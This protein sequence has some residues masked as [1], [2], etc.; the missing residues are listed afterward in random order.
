[1]RLRLVADVP[2][3]A[4]LSG[5]VDSSLVVA[6]MSRI[7]GRQVKTFSIGFEEE[8]FN[9]LP[10]ARLVAERYSTDH[11]ELVVRPQFMDILPTL[12]TSLRRTVC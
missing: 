3:G 7:S 9:E 2:I 12:G 4:L 8:D 10:H 11:H 1:M 5:G 6:L